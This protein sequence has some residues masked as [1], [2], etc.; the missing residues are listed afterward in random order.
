MLKKATAAIVIVTALTIGTAH[1]GAALT[2]D[3]APGWEKLTKH[4]IA[5]VILARFGA[6]DAV[7]QQILDI[8]IVSFETTAQ[9]AY[10]HDRCFPA[11]NSGDLD[12]FTEIMRHALHVVEATKTH[13][14][15]YPRLA[16]KTAISDFVASAV[17]HY[18]Q[19]AVGEEFD[20]TASVARACVRFMLDHG[21][22]RDEINGYIFGHGLTVEDIRAAGRRP[23]ETTA[24]PS[25]T[26]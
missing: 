10:R 14:L 4:D 16:V 6:L 23:R 15:E 3:I 7:R 17:L 2:L 25:V 11:S 21:A 12:A 8:A 19:P 20:Q 13:G 22:S 18:C 5:D 26:P 9:F 24:T 1:R